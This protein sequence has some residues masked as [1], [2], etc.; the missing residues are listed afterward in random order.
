MFVCACIN[1]S[2]AVVV[3]DFFLF[4]VLMEIEKYTSGNQ[5]NGNTKDRDTRSKEFP[6]HSHTHSLTYKNV[7]GCVSLII[8]NNARPM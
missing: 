8:S 5:I 2:F 3:A 7:F 4:G 1:V 6:T